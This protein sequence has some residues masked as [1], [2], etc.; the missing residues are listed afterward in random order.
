VLLRAVSRW[1][2]MTE[3]I[4]SDRTLENYLRQFLGIFMEK[5]LRKFTYLYF[6]QFWIGEK[7]S[8]R[9]LM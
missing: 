9:S 8:G 4:F 3:N 5:N 2:V 6:L 7:M 1:A